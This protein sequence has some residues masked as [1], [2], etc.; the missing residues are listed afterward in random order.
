MNVLI[1]VYQW[2]EEL[3]FRDPVWISIFAP[4]G[5]VLRTNYSRTLAS[6]ATE[7]NDAFYKVP[8]DL[9]SDSLV[10]CLYENILVNTKGRNC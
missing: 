10:S 9:D 7:G 2:F 6:I 3:I 1:C 5:T 4:N 8:N